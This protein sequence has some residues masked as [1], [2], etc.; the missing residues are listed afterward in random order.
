MFGNY[1]D[2]NLTDRTKRNGFAALA[3][4]D[5]ADGGGNGDGKIDSSD[6]VFSKLR[7]WVDANQNG[8]S[9]TGELFTLRELGIESISLIYREARR[10]DQW[11]NKFRYAGS[12]TQNGRQ[13]EKIYDVFLRSATM[14]SKGG[15]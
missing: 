11:G 1:T 9:E 6:A 13:S 3:Y 7:V 5:T 10:E 8:I 14:Q 12:L 2:H 15:K 4:Y